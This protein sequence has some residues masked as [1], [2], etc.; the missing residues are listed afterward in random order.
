MI[1][2]FI[3]QLRTTISSMLDEMHT[4]IPAEITDFNAAECRATVK[5]YGSITHNGI[6]YD[7]PMIS[8]VPI[9]SLFSPASDAGVLVPISK[10]D[11][12]LLVI[13]EQDLAKWLL[14]KEQ[15]V[16]LKYDLSNA[17]AITGLINKPVSHIETASSQKIVRVYCNG[18]K[19]DVAKDS[20]TIQR[21][22]SIVNVTD[23]GISLTG[24]TSVNGNVSINGNLSVSGIISGTVV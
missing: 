13:S 21:G 18:T 24:N 16:E 4:A 9:V 3:S 10:G 20:V 1:Q 17:I 15:S 8:G 6:E 7:Y 11:D 22:G 5:P 23:S 19:V 2:E 12:C 14:G